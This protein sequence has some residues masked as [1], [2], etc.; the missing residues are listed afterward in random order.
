MPDFGAR[1]TSG[2]TVETWT[3]PRANP[4]PSRP[5]RCYRGT[6]GTPIVVTAEDGPL[7]SALSGRLFSARID[8]SPITPS[9]AIS[10]PSGRSSVQQFT[11]TARGHYC[12]V[13]SR[14]YGGAL[15]FHFDV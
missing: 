3:D 1:P 12:L 5:S 11:P 6:I 4:L 2:V 7:D 14:Q 10:S 13:L 9:P 8:Q 15:I